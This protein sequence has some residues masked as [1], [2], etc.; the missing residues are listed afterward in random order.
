MVG[1]WKIVAAALLIFA[2]GVLTGGLSTGAAIRT[3]RQRPA[4]PAHTAAA[5]TNP[6]A[7]AASPAKGSTNRAWGPPAVVQR[8][9]AFRR[10]LA[11]LD[12]DP[13]QRARVDRLAAESNERIRAMWSPVAPRLQQEVRDLRKQIAA[14]LTAEQRERFDALLE[15]RGGT[16]AATATNA[17]PGQALR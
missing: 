2:A 8:I 7:G 10:G 12:L 11:Q 9:E 13:A 17:V 1:T 4:R 14:E 5:T 3:S 16:A 15:R 6:P